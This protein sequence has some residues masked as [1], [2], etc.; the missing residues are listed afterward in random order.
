[1]R[2]D[3]LTK[4]IEDCE[5]RRKVFVDEGR[6]SFIKGM[7]NPLQINGDTLK[8][9]NVVSLSVLSFME[10]D[11]KGIIETYYAKDRD[12]R[13]ICSDL[14]KTDIGVYKKTNRFIARVTVRLVA[15][16]YDGESIFSVFPD[17]GEDISRVLISRGITDVDNSAVHTN[18]ITYMHRIQKNYLISGNSNYFTLTEFI[19]QHCSCRIHLRHKPSTENIPVRIGIGRHGHG[20]KKECPLRNFNKLVSVVVVLIYSVSHSLSPS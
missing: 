19:S 3:I 6:Y 17:I 9:C 18:H 11:T 8:A 16:L 20:S 15:R 10:K 14:V 13:G 4:I 2:V 7:R 12:Y 5:R 1:M